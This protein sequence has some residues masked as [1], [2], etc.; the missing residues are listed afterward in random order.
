[1]SS[2]IVVHCFLGVVD[3]STDADHDSD[4]STPVQ[5]AGADY[6]FGIRS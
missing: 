3:N 2:V 1:M 6:L 5:K 4:L